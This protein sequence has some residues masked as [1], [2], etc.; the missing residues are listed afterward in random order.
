MPQ[1]QSNENSELQKVLLIDESNLRHVSRQSVDRGV[2]LK[3]CPS[4]K[5]YHIKDKLLTYSSLDLSV[6]YFYV[7]LTTSGE[8]AGEVQVTMEGTGNERYFIVWR[9]CCQETF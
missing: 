4:G 3:C 9:I 6:V 8:P 7:R 1:C 2:I 5:I